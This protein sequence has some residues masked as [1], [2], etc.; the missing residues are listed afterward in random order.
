[1]K[2]ILH[3]RIS[4]TDNNVELAITDI[5]YQVTYGKQVEVYE[6]TPSG[7]RRAIDEYMSCVDHVMRCE[8]HVNEGDDD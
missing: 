8:G 2:T 6:K 5:A 1:M 7:L 4:E 3:N